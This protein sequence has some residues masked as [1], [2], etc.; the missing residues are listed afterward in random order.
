MRIKTKHLLFWYL[1]NTKDCKNIELF[2]RSCNLYKSGKLDVR[3]VWA[4]F[5]VGAVETNGMRISLN[6]F[7]PPKTLLREG[8]EANDRS[9]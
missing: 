8:S 9:L 5:E 6:Q 4:K 2:L 1:K 3:W 7:F